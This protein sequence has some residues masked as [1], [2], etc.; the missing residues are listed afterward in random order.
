M[1][2]SQL[3]GLPEGAGL[4]KLQ[5][6]TIAAVQEHLFPAEDNAPGAS[7]INA[8]HY[9]HFVL[10]DETL[11]APDRELI[12]DGTVKLE[13][14][15]RSRLGKQFDRLTEEQKE[16]SLREFESA[17]VGRK[18]ITE[19]LGY[20]FE[21]LLTDPVYGGNPNGVGWKWLGHRPGFPRPPADKRYFLL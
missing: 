12:I 15:I 6:Q 5:W 11:E 17:S 7:D 21:A 19:M 3:D 8:A 18:W 4:N 14:L 1:S 20:I 13:A 9:L 2:T 10:S 16:T